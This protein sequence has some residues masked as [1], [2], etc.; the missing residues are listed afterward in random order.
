MHFTVSCDSVGEEEA[1]KLTERERE[2][3]REGKTG[4]MNVIMYF[5]RA[6]NPV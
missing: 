3:E 2:R 4:L 1:K 5:V 6:F